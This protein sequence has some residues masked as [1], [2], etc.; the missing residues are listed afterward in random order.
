[1]NVRSLDGNVNIPKLVFRVAAAITILVVAVAV[2]IAIR[3]RFREP[4]RGDTEPSPDGKTY[5]AVMNRNDCG[6]LRVDGQ[7]WPFEEGVRH[8]IAPGVHRI[9]CDADAGVE[10]TVREGEIF[11]FD[12][13]GP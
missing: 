1:M 4:L 11:N 13:W 2:V 12:Y 3:A 9:A 6:T 8:A 5:L 10:F 7:P